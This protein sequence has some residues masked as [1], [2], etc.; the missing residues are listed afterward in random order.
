M[1]F[2]IQEAIG[3]IIRL[4]LNPHVNKLGCG[5]DEFKGRVV[6]F[7]IIFRRIRFSILSFYETLSIKIK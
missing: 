1:E 6:G 5:S 7:I 4:E 3:L 2:N